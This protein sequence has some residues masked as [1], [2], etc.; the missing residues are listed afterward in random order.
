[1]HPRKGRKDGSILKHVWSSVLSCTD[2]LSIPQAQILDCKFWQIA[3]QRSHE[4]MKKRE[5]VLVC[6]VM[7]A[8]GQGMELSDQGCEKQPRLQLM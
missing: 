8:E 3:L 2:V 5:V 4:L 6:R 1:M 7:M